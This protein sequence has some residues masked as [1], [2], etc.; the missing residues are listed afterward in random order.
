MVNDDVLELQKQHGVSVL[1]G[2]DG[3]SCRQKA[4]KL[5]EDAASRKFKSVV[6]IEVGVEWG[7]NESSSF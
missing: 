7:R 6:A 3:E 1:L 4:G 5:G 2:K